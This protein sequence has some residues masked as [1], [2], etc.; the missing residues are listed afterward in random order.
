MEGSDEGANNEVVSASSCCLSVAIAPS[1]CTGQRVDIT[2]RRLGG[3]DVC[4][5]AVHIGEGNISNRALS[6]LQAAP[7][8][9]VRRTCGLFWGSLVRARI[10]TLVK[11]HLG[12]KI[13]EATSS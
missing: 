1:W 11:K 2:I 5:T 7:G 9:H 3:T 8:Y 10:A 4:G 6:G 13:P 12:L